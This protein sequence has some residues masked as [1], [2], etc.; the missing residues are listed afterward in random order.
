MISKLNNMLSVKVESLHKLAL[1]FVCITTL[2]GCYRP[3]SASTI[4]QEYP[5][6]K[7]NFSVG[8]NEFWVA[9]YSVQNRPILVQTLGVGGETVLLMATIHGNEPAG[10]PLLRKLSDY[11]QQWPSLLNGRRVVLI[12]VANPDGW[13][14]N[15]RGNANGV[16]LNR[17]F[18]T[19]NR[20]NSN[21]NGNHGLSEPEAVVLKNI[22]LRY[23]PQRIISIHQ[24][25][26]CIDY[27]GPGENLAQ[28]MARQCPLPVKKLGARPGSLG[29]YA[30]VT[31]RIPI[32]TFEMK[33]SDTR[34]SDSQLWSIYG[35]A[36]LAGIEG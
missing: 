32:I 34:L 8:N 12:N 23:R 22:I 31:L 15:T 27:D 21:L 18:T 2:A 7:S 1:V 19:T 6:A 9:G 11:L 14:A 35:R 20:I 3:E 30:G 26:E 13:F 25:L 24:P 10:T 5:E 36:L 29:S 28:K 4:I 16:D 33:K 17:N